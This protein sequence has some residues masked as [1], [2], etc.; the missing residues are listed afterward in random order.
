LR[1]HCED[2]SEINEIVLKRGKRAHAT[3][4]ITLKVG[5]NVA[6][7]FRQLQ[8]VGGGRVGAGRGDHGCAAQSAAA[9]ANRPR[10]RE[11]FG[12]SLASR[13]RTLPRR[14]LTL[15]LHSHVTRRKKNVELWR[16][17]ERIRMAREHPFS[18]ECLPVF[19]SMCHT[20]VTDFVLNVRHTNR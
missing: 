20:F 11:R 2:Q 17:R 13:A 6:A 15:A 5:N 1:R 19:Q 4:D 8:V 9:E 12:R 10:L 7:P 14:L 3:Q 18:L 16:S